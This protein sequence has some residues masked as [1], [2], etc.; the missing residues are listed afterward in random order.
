[1]GLTKLP[2]SIELIS[3]VEVVHL[4]N[5]NLQTLPLS[6]SKLTLLKLFDL[7]NNPVAVE[8]N[9]SGLELQEVPEILQFIS[10]LRNLDLSGWQSAG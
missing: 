6:I 5:N 7:S 3:N 1:M 9:W 4:Q 10:T 2:S 8:I